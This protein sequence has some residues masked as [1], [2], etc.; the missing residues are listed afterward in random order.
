MADPRDV[1]VLILAGG[2]AT[3]LPNKLGLA[4][5]G[6]PLLVRVYRNV[7]KG[8]TTFV[9]CKGTFP[10]EIDAELACPMIVD[11]WPVRGPLAGMLSAMAE[12]P[13]PLV[14]AVAGDAPFV[15]AALIDRLADAWQEGD[16]AVVPVHPTARGETLEP[17]AALYDREAFLREGTPVLDG[18]DASLL[19]TIARLRAR[20]LPFTTAEATIFANVNT[21]DDYAATLA[22]TATG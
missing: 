8:R 20:K 2:E 5:G 18:G 22:R 14:F 12:M 17:L 11:R 3:R 16:E 13:T 4:I 15:D 21:P 6:T 9:S 7:S 19:G 10:P 1:G